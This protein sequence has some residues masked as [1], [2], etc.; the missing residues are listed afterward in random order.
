MSFGSSHKN[1]RPFDSVSRP[2]GHIGAEWRRNPSDCAKIDVLKC[3]ETDA[4]RTILDQISFTIERQDASGIHRVRTRLLV[5]CF[6]FNRHYECVDNFFF[7]VMELF[8]VPS[9]RVNTAFPY[10]DQNDKKWVYKKHPGTYRMLRNRG[11]RDVNNGNE[12]SYTMTSSD[13]VCVSKTLLPNISIEGFF[14]SE[15][16]YF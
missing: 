2:T 1:R 14:P 16:N 4:I 12:I 10:D 3:D 11:F 5:N 7:V 15:T 13:V 9:T 6:K 8:A